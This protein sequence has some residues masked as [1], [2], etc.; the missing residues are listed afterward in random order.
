MASIPPEIWEQVVNFIPA[1]DLGG[2]FSVN[3]TLL[4]L[5]LNKRY[6]DVYFVCITPQL[7]ARKRLEH[8]W[9]VGIIRQIDIISLIT[10]LILVTLTLP[11]ECIDFSSIPTGLLLPCL[12]SPLHGCRMNRPLPFDNLYDRRIKLEPRNSERLTTALT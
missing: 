7:I 6:E 11:P 12:Q 1:E 9:Y 10:V 5:A 8:L 3:N 2:L 4:Q